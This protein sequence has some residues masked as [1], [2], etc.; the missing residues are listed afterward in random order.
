M[1]HLLF[2]FLLGISSIA[3]GQTYSLTGNI[4]SKSGDPMVY[5]TV[6]L[7]NP[8]DSTMEFF[9]ITGQQGHFEIKNVKSGDYLLQ[10]AF[11]GY[12]TYYR[13][14]T[15]PYEGNN[16]GTIIMEESPVGLDEVD[17][18]G[19]HVPIFI[20]RDTIEFNADAFKTRPG[21]VAEDLLKKLPGIEVDRA[22]NIKAMGEDVQRLY[23]DGKEFFGND[24]KVATKN[25]PAD[26]L[27]KVQVYDRKSDEAEFTGL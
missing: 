25:V 20:N 10:S 2:I 22:G 8:V 26:A 3:A 1:R 27:K 13:N 23:V 24:P 4:F 14:V 5:S 16:I 15:I 18:Y 11:L 21:D 17:V 6:V 7:L 12:Q 9:A 19:E